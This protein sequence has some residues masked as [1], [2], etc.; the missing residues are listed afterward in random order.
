MNSIRPVVARGGCVAIAILR[1][2]QSVFRMTV[3]AYSYRKLVA[4]FR[5][6]RKLNGKRV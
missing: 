6:W 2:N 3:I 4:A 5:C 1:E